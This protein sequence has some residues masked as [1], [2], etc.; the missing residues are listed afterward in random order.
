MNRR[1]NEPRRWMDRW[2]HRLAYG[3]LA[4][5]FAAGLAFTQYRA[6]EADQKIKDAALE[7]AAQLKVE[8]ELRARQI[9]QS[10]K[11][12]IVESCRESNRRHDATIAQLDKLIAS[13]PRDRRRRAEAGKVYTVALIDQLQ[14][15]RD[16][17]ARAE[18][19]IP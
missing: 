12:V 1:L 2:G 4:L 11:D 10:R 13:L 5:A 18:R 17:L 19:L 8:A 9:E 16:C 3:L 15:K 7:R 14:P 6:D